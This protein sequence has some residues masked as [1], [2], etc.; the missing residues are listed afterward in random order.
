MLD[1]QY[2]SCNQ[3]CCITCCVESRENQLRFTTRA[4]AFCMQKC[5]ALARRKADEAGVIGM[6]ADLLLRIRGSDVAAHVFGLKLL[7]LPRRHAQLGPP[8]PFFHHYLS[9]PHARLPTNLSTKD[10]VNELGGYNTASLG[11]HGAEGSQVLTYEIED[12]KPKNRPRDGHK[13]HFQEI[14]HSTR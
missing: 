8:P 7:F 13:S 3:S 6:I 14:Q 1:G 11:R 10:Y 2:G 9:S 5:V 12:P 4:A